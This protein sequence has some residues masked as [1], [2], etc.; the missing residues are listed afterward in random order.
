MTT[1]AGLRV[2]AGYC[3]LLA[4]TTTSAV[5]A[6]VATRKEPDPQPIC[7]FRGMHHVESLPETVPNAIASPARESRAGGGW[8]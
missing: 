6:S 8:P 7:A 4:T 2:N 5:A 3:S 1:L